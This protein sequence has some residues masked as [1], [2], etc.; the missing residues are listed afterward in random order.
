MKFVARLFAVLAVVVSVGCASSQKADGKL[1]ESTL[2]S[3]ASVMRWGDVAQALPFIDPAVL[4]AN[5]VDAVTLERF[6]QVQVAG[7][8]ERS[9]EMTG[10]LEARQIVQ[11]D[12]VNRHTQEERTVV[13]QQRWRY[14]AVEKKWWL[15]SGLP[16][17]TPPTR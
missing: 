5:P 2:R 10:E 6:K 14:D 16:D 7:Y 13:D 15:M 12:L 17:I 11:I 3:Y 8:R 4:E 9:L 1:L